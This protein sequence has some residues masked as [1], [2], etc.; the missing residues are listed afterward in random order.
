MFELIVQRYIVHQ[1]KFSMPSTR[2]QKAKEKRSR[3]SNMTSDMEN[4]D[5]ILESYPR[6]EVESQLSENEEN[7]D[8]RSNE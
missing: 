8:R 3:Q 2:N 1:T 7:T 6:N 4:L 5:V